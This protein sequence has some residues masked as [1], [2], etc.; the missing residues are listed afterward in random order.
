MRT[1]S[2]ALLALSVVLGTACGDDDGGVDCSAFTACG[3][4]VTGTWHIAGSCVDPNAEPFPGCDEATTSGSPTETG[5]VT[6]NEDGTY[7][8]ETMLTGSASFMIPGSC[9]AG[10]TSCDMLADET[11]TCTGTIDTACNCEITFN[12]TTSETGTYTTSGNT[13]TITPTG[14]QPDPAEYCVSGNTLRVNSGD[15]TIVLTK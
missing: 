3:G 12:D 5:T 13:I 10:L 14:E 6:L 7:T 1:L 4:D 8:A 9:L 2:L 15:S 11:T